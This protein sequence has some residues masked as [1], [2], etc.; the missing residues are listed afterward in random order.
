[1][2]LWCLLGV[3]TN[4]HASH[5]ET[6]WVHWGFP[7]NACACG[8]RDGT[9]GVANSKMCFEMTIFMVFMMKYNGLVLE[10]DG[11]TPKVPSTRE[12]TKGIAISKM[13]C[14]IA[15]F[16]VSWESVS[17]KKLCWGLIKTL[18]YGR[19]QGRGGPIYSLNI[20]EVSSWST[21]PS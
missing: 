4:G 13:W 11:L 6:P 1:M 5:I 10:S 20:L 7:S 9:Y 14:R 12:D 19:K 18:K 2:F 16:R 3:R 17:N 15:L 21:N 8:T